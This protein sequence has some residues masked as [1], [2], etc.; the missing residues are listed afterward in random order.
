MFF[1]YYVYTFIFSLKKISSH[2]GFRQDAFHFGGKDGVV[3]VIVFVLAYNGTKIT[4]NH[5]VDDG[6]LLLL[7]LELLLL[8]WLLAFL[9]LAI[10]FL[11]LLLL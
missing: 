1:Q 3:D 5:I 11:F 2:F 8:I 10:M 4:I 7:F 6:K 9:L